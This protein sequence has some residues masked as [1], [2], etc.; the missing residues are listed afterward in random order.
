MKNASILK[1]C[2]TFDA[3]L[4]ESSRSTWTSNYPPCQLIQ[5]NTKT[6]L[7][8]VF[9]SLKDLD[10][11][12]RFR[13]Q[14]GGR[15]TSNL[16][17]KPSFYFTTLPSSSTLKSKVSTTTLYLDNLRSS[18]FNDKQTQRSLSPQV[19][20]SLK[21]LDI[22][23]R[24]RGQRGGRSTNNLPSD[25]RYIFPEIETSFVTRNK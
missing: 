4:V 24:S 23:R 7:I 5:A 25:A 17:P 19:F 20:N 1:K 15:P 21:D 9:N 13:G 18:S 8:Q 11:L 16:R 2:S 3:F 14:R 6:A 12:R 10:I 22:L